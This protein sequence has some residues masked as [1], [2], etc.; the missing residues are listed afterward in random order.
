VRKRTAELENNRESLRQERQRLE[1]VIAGS[2]LGVWEWNVQTNETFFNETW[3]ELIGYTL[4]ELSPYNY[5]T[6]ESLLH[7]DDVERARDMLFA[8]VEGK[9]VNYE[10][11]IRMRH[12]DGRW[13]WILDRGQVFTRDAAGNPLSM[14][15]THTDIT[16]IKRVEE[17]ARDTSDLLLHFIENSPIYA[18]IKEVSPTESRTLMAS[19]NYQ[20][21]IGMTA[22]EMIGKT[23][24]ELFPPEFA[25]QITADD[26]QVVSNGKILKREEMLDGRTYTT[27]KF[28]IQLG[29][30]SLLAGYT[31]DITD[32]V[33]AEE[34]REK[35][36]LQLIQSQKMESVGRLAGGVAHDFNN[37][38]SVIIG[39]CE[40]A[41]LD[42]DEKHPLC[43][44]LR[45]ILKAAEHSADLT[46]KLLAFARKQTV[47]PKVLDIN[48]TVEGMLDMLRRLIGE[49]I[50]LVW[51]PK[52]MSGLVSCQLS[53]VG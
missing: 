23:M 20:G 49:G 50:D 25:D 16:T 9:T 32:R 46:R 53:S 44:N 19:D 38:L 33:Q 26:W 39:H 31:I 8:C 7:P 24:G 34:E 42:L 41:L 21:M 22:A 11:E 2:R 18:Y 36:R 5:A 51:T 30:K 52:S 35:L 13:V 17:D 6:W 43:T 45:N 27:I 28:P 37:M 4:E 40:L 29:G 48:A 15:G 1:F 47:A 3:A 14:F 12:K 10:C